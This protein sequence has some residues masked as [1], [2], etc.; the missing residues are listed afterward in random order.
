MSLLR[1]KK[2]IS[3]TLKPFSVGGRLIKKGGE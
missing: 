3:Y 2:K 1:K